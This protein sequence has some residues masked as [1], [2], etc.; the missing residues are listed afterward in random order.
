MLYTISIDRNYD[1]D[2]V[3]FLESNSALLKNA[4]PART[5]RIPVP[6]NRS[7]VKSLKIKIPIAS[8]TACFRFPH[9]DIVSAPASLF[10]WKEETFKKNANSPFPRRNAIVAKVASLDDS[11][12]RCDIASENAGSSP[13]MTANTKDWTAARGDIR[14]KSS[15]EGSAKDPVISRLV[16]TVYR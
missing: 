11:A 9:T 5:S 1:A 7:T 6:F 12:A 10:V 16:V 4:Q 14:N 3:F 2:V 8:V 13:A 15:I